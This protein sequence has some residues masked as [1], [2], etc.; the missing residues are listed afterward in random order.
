MSEEQDKGGGYF[1]ED[2]KA[3]WLY[4]FKI[5][6]KSS[7][8]GIAAIII[9]YFMNLKILTVGPGLPSSSESNSLISSPL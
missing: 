9:I 7:H 4:Y 3:L 8:Y 6:T 2:Q 1:R 5:L